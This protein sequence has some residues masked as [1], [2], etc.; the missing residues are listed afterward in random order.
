MFK[1]LQELLHTME[2]KVVGVSV[3]EAAL[4]EPTRPHGGIVRV[5]WDEFYD[6]LVTKPD[7]FAI[8]EVKET[9]CLWPWADFN[10]R[11]KAGGGF[12]MGIAS[13]LRL[14]PERKSRFPELAQALGRG[15]HD[16]GIVQIVGEVSE[17]QKAILVISERYVIH[18]H[19][20][21]V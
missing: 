11:Q 4:E 9:R 18:R 19:E 21:C 6:K 17:T 7:D 14:P 5:W 13:Y 15:D 2:G 20:E 16:T 10:L 8:A 3:A 1:T 12:V